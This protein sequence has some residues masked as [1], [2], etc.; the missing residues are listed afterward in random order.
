[1]FS[2]VLI[3]NFLQGRR[4]EKRLNELVATIAGI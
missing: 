1:M 4:E 3:S 2:Y